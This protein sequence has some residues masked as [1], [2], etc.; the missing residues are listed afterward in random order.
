[1]TD[2][3]RARYKQLRA[4]GLSPEDA[5]A[6][7][8][9]TEDFS[10][11][12]AKGASTADPDRDTRGALAKARDWVVR[13]ALQGASL[14][15]SDELRGVGAA[16][17]PGGDDY[18][19]ARD[20]ERAALDRAHEEAPVVSRLAEIAGGVAVPVGAYGQATKG[21][22]LLSRMAAGAKVAGVSGTVGGAGISRGD[23]G[24]IETPLEVLPEAA[25]GGV[26]GSV[27]GAAF[28]LLAAARRNAWSGIKQAPGVLRETV[29]GVL[30]GDG[31]AQSAVKSIGRRAGLGQ[32]APPRSLRE[33]V[34]Q[35]RIAH[36]KPP[37]G[38]GPKPPTQWLRRGTFEPGLDD[39]TL[40]DDLQPMNMDLPPPRPPQGGGRRM[41]Q[42]LDDE[43]LQESR[44]VPIERGVADRLRGNPI[45]E[46]LQTLGVGSDEIERILNYS[47][48][49]YRAWV[50]SIR[51]GQQGAPRARL[52][53][54]EQRL[55][56]PRVTPEPPQGRGGGGPDQDD[57]LTL[58]ERSVEPPPPK[59]VGV[60]NVTPNQARTNAR[61]DAADKLWA[62][63]RARWGEWAKANPAP[64]E[65][66]PRLKLEREIRDLEKQV[67]SER[68]R[69]VRHVGFTERQLARRRAELSKLVD[70][71]APSPLDL[72]KNE[73]GRIG[74]LYHG[75]PHKFDRFDVSKIGTGEGAQ[76][77]GHGLYFTETPSV[78]AHYR[79]VLSRQGPAKVRFGDVEMDLPTL[80]GH[81][82]LTSVE[83][84][85]LVKLQNDGELDPGAIKRGLQAAA[86]WYDNPNFEGQDWALAYRDAARSLAARVDDV[87]GV[88][89]LYTA[90]LPTA[91]ADDFLLWDKPLSQQSE[92]VRKAVEG[93]VR[94]DPTWKTSPDVRMASLE[95]ADTPGSVLYDLIHDRPADAAGA[96]RKAGIRGIKYLDGSSRKAG[97]GSYNYVVFD[98]QDIN[99]LSRE[100]KAALGMLAGTG[101]AAGAA[102]T[103]GLL[104][105]RKRENR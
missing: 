57:L 49:E 94:G 43:I 98:D 19:T 45:A 31:V 37:Q 88:G 71:S 69:N 39:L 46:E 16:L 101:A 15:F 28:P 65:M 81:R 52:R 51:R 42:M 60:S 89:A 70:Q 17:V 1:M 23:P 85:L 72:L 8:Q 55:N 2:P 84:D 79:N 34:E 30:D 83:R 97:D 21:A 64:P 20:K 66:Q 10:D 100:G 36:G 35:S 5:Y 18:T 11:V 105:N 74:P 54:D 99:I 75:S 59:G 61:R 3:R 25:I 24:E 13:P 96:L 87:S 104:A 62:D 77:Y 73:D 103:G 27:T 90:E 26:V 82:D 50:E 29:E 14:G 7:A 95:K 41:S 86:N 91:T 44:R 92:K 58:L 68:Q 67:R 47:P 22:G 9:Q 102:L 76:V 63:R 12:T 38:M 53:A 33:V 80:M 93:I 32:K 4:Q 40:V 78:A 56:L 6:Q 48:D